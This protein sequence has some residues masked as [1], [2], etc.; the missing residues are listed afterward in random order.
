MR[1]LSLFPQALLLASGLQLAA[2]AAS[3]TFTEASLSVQGKG[4]G[5]GGGLKEKFVYHCVYG[6]CQY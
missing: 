1:L 2:A 5:V 4:A 3:W 6:Y